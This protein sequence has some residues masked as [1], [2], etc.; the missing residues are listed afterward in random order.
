MKHPVLFNVGGIAL[1]FFVLDLCAA[2]CP[3]WMQ[4]IAHAAMLAGFA[5]FNRATIQKRF[6][7]L[8]SWFVIGL[9]VLVLGFMASMPLSK[10]AALFGYA[11]FCVA[12]FEQFLLRGI[13]FSLTKASHTNAM[14]ILINVL[15]SLCLFLFDFF[16]SSALHLPG[17]S[18][19][20]F[21][22]IAYFVL[23]QWLFAWYFSM[24]ENLWVCAL[25]QFQVQTRVVSFAWFTLFL[26]IYLVW[27]AHSSRWV[28]KMK[29][30]I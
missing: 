14:T 6:F 17:P 4:G 9:F 23:F 20:S 8:R 11:F 27:H 10:K 15:M 26:G 19:L 30:W 18:G 22:T 13:L 12:F 24:T 29:N 2:F 28:E 7:S 3:L 25:F 21:G 1:A 16:I 5:W